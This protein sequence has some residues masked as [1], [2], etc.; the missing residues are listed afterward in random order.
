MLPKV[1]NRAYGSICVVQ[2]TDNDHMSHLIQDQLLSILLVIRG[3][4]IIFLTELKV[5]IGVI[6]NSTSV[7]LPILWVI[8]LK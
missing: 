4:I 2:D 1:Y 7:V 6:N 3:I 8:L 5:K